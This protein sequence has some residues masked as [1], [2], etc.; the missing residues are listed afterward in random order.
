MSQLWDKINR[1]VKQLTGSGETSWIDILNILYTIRNYNMIIYWSILILFC[2]LLNMGTGYIWWHGDFLGRGLSQFAVSMVTEGLY[3]SS[4]K[5][6]QKHEWLF[7][8]ALLH[9]FIVA[10]ITGFPDW[11]VLRAH[12]GNLTNEVHC[13]LQYYDLLFNCV[14]TQF[15]WPI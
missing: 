7:S 3:H 4:P 13:F 9:T 1:R 10:I 8:R 6:T 5:N 15:V 12:Y 11:K 2:L 14:H